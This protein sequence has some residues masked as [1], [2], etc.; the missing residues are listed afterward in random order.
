MTRAT[1][2]RLTIGVI[3]IALIS[4]IA[5]FTYFSG[6]AI[7][8]VAVGVLLLIIP[9]RIQDHFWKDYLTGQHLLRRGKHLEALVKFEKFLDLLHR[10]PKLKWLVWCGPSSQTLDIEVMTLNNMGLC[11]LHLS[12]LERAVECFESAIGL[13]PSSALPY[14]NLSVVN[15]EQGNSS[16][17]ELNS[18]KAIALGY[19]PRA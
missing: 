18:Q 2:Y 14:H 9:G 11:Y 1:R 19:R 5:G 15:E 10:K 8:A 12:N 6:G 3:T 16:G 4:A 17:A 13:D 7:W